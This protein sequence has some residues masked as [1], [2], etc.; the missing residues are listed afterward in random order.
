MHLAGPLSRTQLSCIFGKY[1]IENSG[2]KNT[3][4]PQSEHLMNRI[5]RNLID[6]EADLGFPYPMKFCHYNFKIFV[7]MSQDVTSRPRS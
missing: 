7:S 3:C 4:I 1:N 6:N 5:I 2:A